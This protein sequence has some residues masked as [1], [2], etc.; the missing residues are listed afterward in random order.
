[1][2]SCLLFRYFLTA[3]SDSNWIGW[4]LG[5]VFVTSWHCLDHQKISTVRYFPLQGIFQA[6]TM[7]DTRSFPLRHPWLQLFPPPDIFHI[8]VFST[9]KTFSAA[10]HFQ[11][12]FLGSRLITSSWIWISRKK[13]SYH[14]SD[15]ILYIRL[16]QNE[17]LTPPLPHKGML[18]HSRWPKTKKVR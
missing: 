4:S 13:V 9:M 12:W 1:M 16:I 6:M 15:R 17:S 14:Y 18:I 7:L 2:Y 10:R 8:K 5:N 11:L 3:K